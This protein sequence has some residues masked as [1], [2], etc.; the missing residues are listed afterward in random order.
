MTLDQ[1]A[2]DTIARAFCRANGACQCDRDP[3]RCHA[4]TLYLMEAAAAV[5]AL[6]REGRLAEPRPS[7]VVEMVEEFP[8]G[9][10]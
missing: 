1:A 2:H 10:A 8:E 4:S 6:K 9:G 5:V 3:R 7:P